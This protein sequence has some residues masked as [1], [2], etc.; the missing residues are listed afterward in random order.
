MQPSGA[1]VAS[2]VPSSG[3]WPLGS[4]ARL[5]HALLL[6]GLLALTR[7]GGFFA[8]ARVT[9]RADLETIDGV[10]FA[11]LV[12]TSI[13]SLG[14]VIGLGLLRWGRLSLADLGWSTARPG[15]DLARGLLG[16]AACCGIVL[17]LRM[18]AG[19]TAA[20]ALQGWWSVPPT[21]RLL[22]VLIGI[23]AAL[24]EETLFRGDLQ[25]T[26]Q[27]MLGRGAGLLLTA[28]IFAAYH[29]R[30]GLLGLL[31]KTAFG[32]LFGLLRD[33]TGGRLLSPALAHWISW[34]VMGFR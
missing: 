1:R 29:L 23:E 30:F 28:L 15:P 18:S 27:R 13:L 3:R 5:G 7:V 22:I 6:V 34:T 25:P 14:G 31:G 17:L 11:V 8:L 20:E 19:E 26:L 24:T 10:T 9:G 4:P 21:E 32:L 2:T 33:R 12:G 16:G